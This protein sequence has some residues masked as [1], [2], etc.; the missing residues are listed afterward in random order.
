MEFLPRKFHLHIWAGF[1]DHLSQIKKGQL[2]YIHYKVERLGGMEQAVAKTFFTPFEVESL[3]R[4]LSRVCSDVSVLV[5]VTNE[6]KK[7]VEFVTLYDIKFTQHQYLELGYLPSFTSMHYI[8]QCWILQ[9]T[10]FH[11]SKYPVFQITLKLPCITK[12]S[13]ISVILKIQ[14]SI[15]F[16][17]LQGQLR[18]YGHP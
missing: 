2:H 8:M 6:P 16:Y 11:N 13:I 10:I 12:R 1:V 9:I 17:I 18:K 5:V 7:R 3:S 4:H 14:F 15:G